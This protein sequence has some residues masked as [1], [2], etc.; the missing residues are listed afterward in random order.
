LALVT[1]YRVYTLGED[2][3]IVR[4]ADID[5]PHDEAAVERAQNLA[6]G[7]AVE[8]WEG[9]RLIALIN[10]DGSSTRYAAN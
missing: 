1:G 6:D 10:K 9:T 5:C 3:H 7:H 2:G 8:L 4:R